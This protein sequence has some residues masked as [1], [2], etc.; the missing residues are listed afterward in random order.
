MDN[1][2]KLIFCR[3]M[4]EPAVSSKENSPWKNAGVLCTTSFKADSPS[5]LSPLRFAF[6]VITFPSLETKK[7]MFPQHTGEAKK[8]PSTLSLQRVL[9]VSK[10]IAQAIPPSEIE[11][12]KS[13]ITKL[14]G[15]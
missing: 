10:S 13:S 4:N 3:N 5:R 6:A 9:P 7:I 8:F 2:R 15:T 12:T 14:V 11:K 1:D